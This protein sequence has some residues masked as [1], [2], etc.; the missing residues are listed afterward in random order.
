M[1][2]TVGPLPP[3][4]YWRRRAV[5]LGGL[6]LV[7]LLVSYAC[8]GS[9]KP[10]AF[11]Q[12]NTL[13]G[14]THSPSPTSS[15]LVPT[16]PSP[17]IPLLTP[18]DSPSPTG[19][20]PQPSGVVPCADA[21]ILVTP[22]ISSTSAKVT[23]LQYGGTFD[24][25]LKVRNISSHPCTRDVGSQPEELRIVAGTK[26]VWSSDDCGPSL[27]AA[28]AVRTFAPGVEIYA[29]LT[30]NSYHI[31]PNDCVKSATPAHRGTYQI[32]GRVGTKTSAPVS[33]TIQS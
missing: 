29:E 10:D 12:Q 4:V 24:L 25:K 15:V 16:L 1:N 7:I 5:V 6:L 3:A 2:L 22:V 28:H 21:D 26:K 31:M 11:G 23:K 32:I 17:S 33:F 14:A 8:G 27:A 19:G 13:T 18:T 30:W 20:S 9:G